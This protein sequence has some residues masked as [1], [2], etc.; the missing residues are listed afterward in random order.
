MCST[1]TNCHQLWW[2]H[3]SMLHLVITQY[4]MNRTVSPPENFLS[5]IE[6]HREAGNQEVSKCETDQ[7]IVVNSS[8]LGVENDAGDN[9]EIGEDCN[10]NDGDQSQGFHYRF[11]IQYEFLLYV[12]YIDVDLGIVHHCLSVSLSVSLLVCP[13]FHVLL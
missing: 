10:N 1:H 5:C 8:Q 7:E 11:K 6:C 4:R 3:S 9:Q 13:W 2:S 12:G